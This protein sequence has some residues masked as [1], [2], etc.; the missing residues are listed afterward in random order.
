[1]K[2][3]YCRSDGTQRLPPCTISGS[4]QAASAVHFSFNSGV[5]PQLRSTGYQ[6]EL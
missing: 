5:T 2:G 6:T 3:V 1:M 4:L